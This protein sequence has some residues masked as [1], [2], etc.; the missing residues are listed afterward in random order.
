MACSLFDNSDPR[1]GTESAEECLERLAGERERLAEDDSEVLVRPTYTYDITK[2]DLAQVQE[3]IVEGSDET[4]GRRLLDQSRL[5]S[6]AVEQFMSMS[7]DEKDPALYRVRGEPV[8]SRD[9]VARGCERQG[10]GMRLVE[11]DI[12]TEESAATDESEI[13]LPVESEN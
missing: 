11:I 3:L 12:P 13:D 4:A 2:L 10:E 8:V 9:A 5:E 1:E 6:S 7:V